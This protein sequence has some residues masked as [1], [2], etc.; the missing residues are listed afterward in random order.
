MPR[1][2][3]NRDLFTGCKGTHFFLYTDYQNL[4]NNYQNYGNC[5]SREIVVSPLYKKQLPYTAY[6]DR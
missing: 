4:G 1:H 6:T 5:I 2:R 3:Q